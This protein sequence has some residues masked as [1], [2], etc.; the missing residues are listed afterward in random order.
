MN[1]QKMY[2][3]AKKAKK[4]VNKTPAYVKWEKKGEMI[5]GAFVS[6]VSIGS[7]IAD[8][9]YNQYLFDTDEGLV[10]FALG[11]A[12]DNEV[13]HIF[14]EGCVYSVEFLGKEDIQGGKRVNKFSIH[15]IELGDENQVDEENPKNDGKPDDQE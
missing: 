5:I 8:G 11:R 6:S 1:Y 3:K 14:K 15:E 12:A 9:E 2:E 13:N 4:L 7:K 10:K